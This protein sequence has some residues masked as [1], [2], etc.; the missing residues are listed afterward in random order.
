MIVSRKDF[1]KIVKRLS[2]SGDYGLDT[3]TTGVRRTDE[4]FSII[5]ADAEDGYYFSFND[6]PDHLGNLVPEE[7]RLPRRWIEDLAPIFDNEKS[8]FFIHNAK[9]DLRMLSKEGSCILGAVH[10]TEAM[11]RVLKNDL[12]DGAYNLAACAERRGWAKDESVEE[13]MRKHK[14]IDRVPVAGKSGLVELWH[15]DQVPFQIT[16]VRGIGD[17]VLHRQI[18]LDQ[19]AQLKKLDEAAPLGH[20]SFEPLIQNERRFTKTLFRMEEVGMHLDRDFTERSYKHTEGLAE[21]AKQKFQKETGLPFSDDAKTLVEAFRKFNIELPKTPTG[22]PCTNKAVLEAL[23]NPIAD[24]IR[25]IRGPQKLIST[26][27]SSFLMYA[28]ESNLVHPNIRQGGTRTGRLSYWEPNLQNLPKEDDPDDQFREFLVRRCFVPLNSEWALVPIDFRQ[29]EFKLMADYAGEKGIIDA[30]MA[31]MDFHEATAQLL[32]ITRKQA[33]TINFGLLYGM[34]VGKLAKSLGVSL[35]E[36][37]TLKAIYFEKL[38]KV[39]E[40]IEN[41]RNVAAKRGYIRNWF[42]FRNICASS[43]FSYKMP[44]ALI[45]GGCGQLIRIASNRLDDYIIENRLR[46]HMTAQIHD[47]ILFQVPKDEFHHVPEFKRIMESVYKPRNGLLLDCDVEHSFKSWAKWDMQKGLP[48][49]A[50]AA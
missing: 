48:G 26:Y 37:Y 47:E 45:Q 25:E 23:E 41:V 12:P 8:L 44:N 42:G 24:L 30:C 22:K 27:Y 38:P 9:F 20:P 17:A 16:S 2:R 50:R 32:G 13:Y 14:L 18:G 46:A 21:A 10:C 40:F 19:L 3:E 15:M 4:L 5:L 39:K 33:K 28:D 11:E 31:G 7:Y 35:E 29:Q 36:A 34:G 1:K 6:A 49:L 43:E